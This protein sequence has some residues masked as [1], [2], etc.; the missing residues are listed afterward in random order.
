MSE[1]NQKVDA[2]IG[3]AKQWGEE[4]TKLREIL[5]DADLTEEIKWGKPCYTHEGNN[6]AILQG[7]KSCC[8]LMFF[9]GAALNDPQDILRK[10]GENTQSARRV[11][12]TAPD[13]I[14][15]IEPVLKSYVREAI[16][17]EKAGLTAAFREPPELVLP[18]EFQRRLDDNPTLREA[19][20]SLTPGRQRQYSLYFSG[21]KQSKTRESRVEKCVPQIL[22]GKGLND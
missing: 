15:K 2:F 5:L 6:I 3:R 1:R 7:F 22:A 9:N 4:F 20:E 17:A 13:E 19:F 21:A 14:E 18:D 10:P 8:A 16:E 11:E 12:F